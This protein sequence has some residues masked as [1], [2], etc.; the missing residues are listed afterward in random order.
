M[1][2]IVAALAIGAA[3]LAQGALSEVGKDAY[4]TLKAA[5]VRLV[6]PRDVEKLEENPDSENRQ[7]VIAEELAKADKATTTALTIQAQQLMAALKETG[8]DEGATGVSLRE[9]E[10]VNAR[11]ENIIA[12]GTGVSVE[13]SRFSG[14]LAIRGVSAGGQLPGKSERR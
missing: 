14:D 1:E 6:S 7:G 2:A 10:A 12:S 4:K 5:V 3:T 8:L 9:V 13:K 11:L